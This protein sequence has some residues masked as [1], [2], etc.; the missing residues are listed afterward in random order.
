MLAINPSF[1][2][3]SAVSFIVTSGINLITV[4]P[5]MVGG[6]EE[7][8]RFTRQ[9]L[10]LFA[11]A[12]T[13]GVCLCG[14]VMFFLLAR[15]PLRLLILTGLSGLFILHF[16]SVFIS[17]P[18]PLTFVRL[19]AGFFGGMAYVSSL[20]WFAKLPQPAHGYANYIVVYSLYS[21]ILLVLFP[22]IIHKGGVTSG[23]IVL[24]V[25]TGV[26]WIIARRL[27]WS[28]II[29]TESAQPVG[30]V[31]FTLILV[32]LFV[33]FVTFQAGNSS[34]Y[35][36]M[37]RIGNE[38]NI[39]P[40]LNGLAISSSIGTGLLAGYLVPKLSLRMWSE[41]QVI[42]GLSIMLLCNLILLLTGE[43]F[44]QFLVAVALFGFGFNLSLPN[45]LNL[46]ARL[47]R[48]GRAL[49][50]GT[51]TNWL[52]QSIG[53]LLGAFMLGHRPY[54]TIV[55]PS[56][57]FL[58]LALGALILIRQQEMKKKLKSRNDYPNE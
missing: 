48:S 20:A 4:L 19:F 53:P 45:F 43:G 3:L 5:M 52:G 13:L 57:L 54:L 49:A 24:T 1:W 51:V 40:L 41:H 36:F 55:Y 37:E 58:F 34:L 6:L 9:A 21:A 25:L 50:L 33:G 14:V 2:R 26:A 38:K 10:G 47:D 18:G 31:N 23:W 32:M 28:E 7:H 22:F 42:L 46:F 27:T 12:D 15:F 30:Q 16:V 39:Q 29:E 11:S 35:S 44:S 17:L 8:Y 56:A